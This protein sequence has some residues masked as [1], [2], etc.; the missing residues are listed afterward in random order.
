MLTG[1]LS[2]LLSV[3]IHSVLCAGMELIRGSPAADAPAA[4][5]PSSSVEARGALLHMLCGAGLGLLFWLSWGLAAVVAV[6]WWLRGASFASLCWLALA[7]PII[8]D[9]LLAK[10]ITRSTAVLTASRWATTC[11]IAGLACAWSW[12]RML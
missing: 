9:Q 2:G 11:M 8:A 12:A 5:P 7:A 6:P 4:P 1:S 10:R 3:L